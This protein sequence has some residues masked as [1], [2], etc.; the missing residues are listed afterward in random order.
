MKVLHFGR[1]HNS[2]FGGLERHV[3]LLLDGLKKSQQCAN[4]VANDRFRAES[5][6]MKGYTVYKAPSLGLV[7][8]TAM[9]PTMPY[10]ARK[11]DRLHGFDI[12]HL[13]FPD[14]MSHLAA[15]FLPRRV[16]IIVTWHSDIV[17]QKTALLFYRPFLTRIINR[18]DAII[19]ATPRH[20]SSSIQ[21]PVSR[22]PE[23]FRVVPYG[24]D[25]G[26]FENP[27][28]AA[29]GKVLRARF[30]NRPLIFAVGRHVYYKGYEYLLRAMKQLTANATLLLGGEGPLTGRLKALAEELKLGN[31]VVFLGR[32]DDADL[33]AHYHAAE[34]FCMPSVEPTEAF[35]LVQV[36]AMAC[37]KPVICCELNNGCTYVNRH[38]ITGLVVPPRDPGA[39]AA[40]MDE[41]LSDPARREQMGDAA[42]DRAKNEFT[43]ERMWNGTLD[44][45]R[46]VL[47]VSGASGE[48][49]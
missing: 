8:G 4:L 43:L 13:H 12:A 48:S 28:A 41:L 2:N 15:I 20:F 30:G 1:F 26:P 11:L 9:C 24:I 22:H 44:V 23:R 17:R 6:D 36:E 3:A 19:A 37:R 7:A 5:V 46:E 39:L 32:I 49:D 18:A 34:L 42:H 33:A 40:A 25:F 38:G 31:R 21:L 47:G 10:W 29:A 35:G 45:Y 16:R 27:Q 14:P